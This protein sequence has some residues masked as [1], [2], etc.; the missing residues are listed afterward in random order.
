MSKH[1]EASNWLCSAVV[2]LLDAL[3]REGVKKQVKEEAKEL[4]QALEEYERSWNT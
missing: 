3:D 2:E 4:R 1:A